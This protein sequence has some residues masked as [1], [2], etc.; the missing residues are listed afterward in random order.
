MLGETG[1]DERDERTFRAR[2]PSMDL[3][4]KNILAGAALAGEKNRSLAGGGALGP[5]Q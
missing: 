3:M 2:T 4:R 5:L 1:T